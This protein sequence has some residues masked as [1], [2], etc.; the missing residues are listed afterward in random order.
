[1]GLGP[2]TDSNINQSKGALRTSG[3]ADFPRVFKRGRYSNESEVIAS[4]PPHGEEPALIVHA[5]ETPPDIIYDIH[6]NSQRCVVWHTSNF[7]HGTNTT[8]C[9]ETIFTWRFGG[10]DVKLES[11]FNNFQE[12]VG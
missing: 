2:S 10:R 12:K 7:V 11:D 4:P 5:S 6:D 9:R 8:V 1:M 3:G